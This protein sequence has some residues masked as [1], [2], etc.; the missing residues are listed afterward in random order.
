MSYFNPQTLDKYLSTLSETGFVR[1][2]NFLNE[3]KANELESTLSSLNFDIAATVNG[4]PQLFTAEELKRKS[5]QEQQQ[6][7]S[8]IYEQASQGIGF[9]YGRHALSETENKVLKNYE[10]EINNDGFLKSFSRVSQ[11]N[12]IKASAQATCFQ[13][14]DFLTR[15]NDVVPS[16]GRVYAYVL[17]LT[18]QWHPDWGGLLQFF[19]PDGTPT[20]S[21][22]PQ[23]NSLSI[24]DV[25]KIHSVTYVTPFAKNKRFS[26]TGWFRTK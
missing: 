16:E 20:N 3:Q 2:P 22:A 7:F 1:I 23:F 19:E 8:H 9:V 12:I 24:F 4:R 11:Q 26:I 14:N 5:N 17:G 18:K 6:L 25:S 15:H 13:R 10:A 21:F